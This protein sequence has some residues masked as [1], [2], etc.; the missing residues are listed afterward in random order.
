[1]K[2]FLELI[3]AIVAIYFGVRVDIIRLPFGITIDIGI[4][5]VLFTLIWIIGITNAVNLIDGLDGLAAGVSTIATV[6]ILLVALQS[7]DL[8]V[9]FLTAA[10]AGASLGF[11]HYN[12]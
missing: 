11:L 6:T 3:A 2:L 9:V 12:F 5:S 1:M 4:F 7:G 8:P 10:L